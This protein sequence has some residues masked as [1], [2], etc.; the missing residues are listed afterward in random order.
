MKKIVTFLSCI[1]ASA[2]FAQAFDG[3]N[4]IKGQ[5]GF[6]T[7]KFGSGIH[8]T[9]DMGLGENISVGLTGVYLLNTVGN[10]I[11]LPFEDRIDIKGRFN[12][13]IG[14]VL[15]LPANVDIYPGLN[16]GTK[17]F[18]AHLGG[19]YF[20]TDGFGLYTEVSFPIAKYNKDANDFN[21]QFVFNIGASFNL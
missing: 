16:L 2:T 11:E 1:I 17:N 5:V 20:F 12:A 6:S 18:G 7:Q 19:R 9:Y 14:S 3:K 21:N 4:D 8:V 13:N 10:G 15:K